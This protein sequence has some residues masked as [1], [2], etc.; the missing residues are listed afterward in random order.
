MKD[1]LRQERGVSLITLAAVIIIMGIITTILLYSISDTKDISKLTNM[2]SDID[3]LEDRIS[4]YYSTYGKIPA[5]KYNVGDELNGIIASWIG[6]EN[7]PIGENDEGDYLVIDLNAIDN[8]TLN[9]GKSY[10]KI[11]NGFNIGNDNK[12]LYVINENS[13]NIFYLQGVEISE[14]KTY[15]TKLDKDA[16]KV[17]IRYVDGI[18]IYDGYNYVEGHKR[19]SNPIKISGDD[20]EYIWVNIDKE[21]LNYEDINSLGVTLELVNRDKF[22]TSV[23]EYNGY[24]FNPT[25]NEG[26]DANSRVQDVLIFDVNENNDKLWSATYDQEGIYKDKNE[27]TAYIPQGFQV[28]KLSSLSTI[29]KGLVIRNANNKQEQYVWIE[30]P[31]EALIDKQTD[32][33]ASTLEE[34]EDDLNKYVNE[35]KNTDYKDTYYE[36]VMPYP[37][38]QPGANLL[39]KYNELKNK[40][41]QSIKDKGGFWIARDEIEEQKNCSNAYKTVSCQIGQR[42][43]SLL[44]GIQWDLVCKLIKDIQPNSENSYLNIKNLKANKEITFESY[45]VK[46]SATDANGKDGNGNKTVVRGGENVYDRDIIPYRQSGYYRATIF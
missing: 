26:R 20:G 29:N 39:A 16:K 3:N 41:Y 9:N 4:N 44:F 34:I 6:D 1:I 18:K 25:K 14:G 2:Y 8:L 19:G 11:K 30:V 12:D 37:E 33:L 35:F 45:I 27:K 22:I 32:K 10:E 21:L 23:N 24:Y 13:H 38:N 40:L 46:N 7:S 5:Q 15:Y 42:E 28:A 43:K 36:G 17:D 31:Q